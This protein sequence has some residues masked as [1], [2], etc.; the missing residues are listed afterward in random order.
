M[1]LVALVVALT[2]NWLRPQSIPLVRRAPFD[3]Y[4]DC[5][6][7]S[8]DLPSVTAQRLGPHPKGVVF[9]DGR[10]AWDYCR[11]HIP[12]AVFLPMYETEP[13][14]P[15]TVRRLHARRGHWIVVYGDASVAGGK[16]LTSALIASGLRGLH[17]LEGGIEAWK[18]QRWNLKTCGIP[19]IDSRNGP[20]DS[21]RL[22]IVDARAP[23]AFAK[24]HVQG[25]INMPFDDVLPP[26]PKILARLLREKRPILVTDS[27]KSGPSGLRP[28]WA[29]A[30]ELKARGARNVSVFAQTM[31]TPGDKPRDATQG[32][33]TV[34]PKNETNAKP[35]ATMEETAP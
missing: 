29:V 9:V 32:S 17:L 20:L 11:G 21:K 25:A 16:R 27:G 2:V 10:K 28:A 33:A 1:G 3:L 26:D 18:K 14:D 23:Q 12:G 15:A 35:Q 34:G 7:V 24:G 30:A 13:P 19:T 6:E 5:P 31:T 22:L 4:T 8:D